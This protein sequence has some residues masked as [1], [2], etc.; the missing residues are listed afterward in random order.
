M[1]YGPRYVEM[2]RQRARMVMRI[3]LEFGFVLPKITTQV[4]SHRD[5]SRRFA[6]TATLLVGSAKNRT[7]Q[8]PSNLACAHPG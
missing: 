2:Y 6:F 7:A 8:A 5:Y 4:V 3:L 1:A